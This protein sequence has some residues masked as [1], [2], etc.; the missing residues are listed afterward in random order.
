MDQIIMDRTQKFFNVGAGSG[1]RTGASN[2]SSDS[3]TLLQIVVVYDTKTAFAKIN[4]FF[5]R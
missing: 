1:A 5:V 3:I 2:L 4:L